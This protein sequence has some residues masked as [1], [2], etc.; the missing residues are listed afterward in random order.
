MGIKLK[1]ESV[2]KP[3]GIAL[4]AVLLSFCAW[5][6]PDFG[7][8]RKGFTVPERPGLLAYFILFSWYLLILASF[9][10]GQKLASS[11]AGRRG[12]HNLPSLDSAA[13]YRT[14]TFLAALGAISTLFRIFSTISVPQAALY[15]YLGQGNRLKNTLY[16]NYSAGLFSLRYLVL[17][18]ASLAIYRTVRFRKL[19]LLNVFNIFLL[20]AT[21]L[22]SSRLIL[23]AT[24]LVSFFLLNYGKSHIRI[25]IT[26]LAFFAGGLFALLSLLNTSRNANFYESRNLSFTEAGISEI[27]TYL[28]SPFH[29]SI[30]AAQRLDELT[31]RGPESYRQF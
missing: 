11:F 10:V 22:V 24:L 5:L 28:G 15:F 4:F 9:S 30:G 7:V 23:I 27:V 21:V 6:C 19:S 14:F 8:L 1:I 26:K 12:G 17:Y 25:S 20:A 29:V 3:S 18:S 13:I 16:A 31:V 2:M